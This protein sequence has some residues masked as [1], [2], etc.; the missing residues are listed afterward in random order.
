VLY[1]TGQGVG[2]DLVVAER[3]FRAAADRG[4]ELAQRNLQILHGE[5]VGK[6]A[7]SRTANTLHPALASA[8]CRSTP[9]T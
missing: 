2:K 8:G 3:W 6:P 5:P 4:A 1:A 7:A 9:R